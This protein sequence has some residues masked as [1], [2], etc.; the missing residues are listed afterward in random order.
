MFRGENRETICVCVRKREKETVCSG[1]NK[2]RLS[3]VMFGY[4]HL[5]EKKFQIKNSIFVA[6]YNFEYQVLSVRKTQIYNHNYK[7]IFSQF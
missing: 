2:G 6:N 1:N 7:Q 5:S 4:T 3:S